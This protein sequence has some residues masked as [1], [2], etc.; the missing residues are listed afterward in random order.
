MTG[1]Q[2]QNLRSCRSH[3]HSAPLTD[4]YKSSFATI[5]MGDK[6]VVVVKSES[7]DEWNPD[8]VVGIDFGMTYTG[9]QAR[10]NSNVH[11]NMHMWY[12][13][14]NI[15]KELHIHPHQN[16]FLQKPSNAGQESSPE[17][18]RTKCQPASSTSPIRTRLEAGG[19][20]VIQKTK[21]RMLRSFSSYISRLSTKM[22]TLG[23]PVGMTPSVGFKT[24]FNA[25]IS[26]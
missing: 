23:L 9:K 2:I 11:L 13:Y 19:S 25:S 22:S 10:L 12:R 6:E 4:K 7:W 16:G 3:R 1:E 5:A 17:N 26:M 8:I 14:T 24:T 20:N 21:A 15:Y 18:W